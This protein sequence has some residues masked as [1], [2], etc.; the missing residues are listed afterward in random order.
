MADELQPMLTGGAVE[1]IEVLGQPCNLRLPRKDA[2]QNLLERGGLEK[3]V[4]T[5]DR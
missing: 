4:S 1:D 2:E 3:A 5:P